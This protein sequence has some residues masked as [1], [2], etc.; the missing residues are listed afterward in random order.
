MVPPFLR[1]GRDEVD[2]DPQYVH[3]GGPADV[4]WKCVRYH[5]HR[6][7]CRDYEAQL[8]RCDERM[9]NGILPGIFKLIQ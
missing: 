1:T 5:A 2:L 4:S 7:K 9:A 3:F 8:V 6:E